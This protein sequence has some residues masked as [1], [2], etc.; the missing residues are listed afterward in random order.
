MDIST[1][2]SP[3][4]ACFQ[5]DNRKMNDQ[6]M[7]IDPNQFSPPAPNIDGRLGNLLDGLLTAITGSSNAYADD[8]PSQ[9]APE[10]QPPQATSRY[11]GNACDS[12][13]A[14][15]SIAENGLAAGAGGL[16]LG[17]VSGLAAGGPI[18]AVVGAAAAGAAGG[19]LTGT[20]GGG[21]LHQ[22]GCN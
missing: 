5:S 4:P 12:E 18:G 11:T 20:V 15:K 13:G 6:N 21:A 16:V 7:N 9:T 17:T 8:L 3:N 14:V 1:K 10:S 19:M 22:L 2:A